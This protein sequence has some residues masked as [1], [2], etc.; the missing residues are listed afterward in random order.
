MHA[1]RNLEILI[2]SRIAIGALH[3]AKEPLRAFCEWARRN[4]VFAS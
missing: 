4:A 1:L 3:D 2:V